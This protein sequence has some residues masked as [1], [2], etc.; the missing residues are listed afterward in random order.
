[1]KKILVTLLLIS[2]QA[3]SQPGDLDTSFAD[4]GIFELNTFK[5]AIHITTDPQENIICTAVTESDEYAV[6][7]LTPNGEVDTNF[8][9]NGSVFFDHIIKKTLTL[10]NG[11]ILVLGRNSLNGDYFATVT[12]LNSDGSINNTFGINGTFS[13]IIVDSSDYSKVLELFEYENGYLIAC[14]ELFNGSIFI[15]LLPNGTLD[16]AYGNNGKFII[17]SNYSPDNVSDFTIDAN[18]NVYSCGY[19]PG[20][21]HHGFLI[22]KINAQG[23]LDSN[24]GDNGNVFINVSG[25]NNWANSIKIFE[26]SLYI[27]GQ[28]SSSEGSSWLS[29]SKLNAE[30]GDLE[31]SFGSYGDGIIYLDGSGSLGGGNDFLIQENGKLIL[32]G[33]TDLNF[34][35]IKRTKIFRVNEDGT[36]N[37]RNVFD[38]YYTYFSL[39]FHQGTDAFLAAGRTYYYPSNL[40]ISKFNVGSLGVEDITGGNTIKIYPNPTKKYFE[41]ESK[42]KIT[43]VELYNVLGE[44]IHTFKNTQHFDVSRFA[45]GL[46]VVKLESENSVVSKKLVIK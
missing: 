7:K 24:F 23:E 27:I 35:Q 39:A 3:F 16:T 20:Y 32:S 4:N 21:E 17:P 15:K 8:G 19:R 18:N 38:F 37:Y 28:G 6:L 22:T 26:N 43:K 33:T 13:E 40:L 46:Y 29:I 41:I 31:T 34:G 45:S 36:L 10:S 11:K 1:M 2:I 44:K 5:E 14:R 25:D 30:N 42:H 9:N 12:M